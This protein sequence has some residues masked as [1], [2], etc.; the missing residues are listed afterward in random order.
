MASVV[1]IRDRS[2]PGETG[3]DLD[4]LFGPLY[5]RLGD[6]EPR[7]ELLHRLCEQLA[8]E[9][10]AAMVAIA[11]KLDSG[12][13]GIEAVAPGNALW[14]ELQAIPERWDGTV[15]GQGPAA[16]SIKSGE[17][18]WISTAEE[19]FR[20]WRAAATAERVAAAGAWPIRH[21][22]QTWL[23]EVF[24]PDEA[25]F[26]SGVVRRKMDRVVR[27][28][29]RFLGDEAD[30]HQR[31]LLASAM[32]QAGHAA[33]ITNLEGEIVWVNR[34]FT[35]L[36]GYEPDEVR[37]KTPRLLHSGQQGLRYYRDLWATIRAGRV[38]SG[39]TVDRDRGGND[40]TVRQT[41]SPFGTGD[42][43]THYLSMHEDISD[44]AV[45]R[46]QEA[47]KQ[48]PDPQT[49]LLNPARFRAAVDEAIGAAEPF[50]L[51]LMSLRGYVEATAGLGPELT[52]AIEN[53][54]AARLRTGLGP[55]WCAG[56]DKPGEYLLLLRD[57]KVSGHTLPQLV[58]AL[59]HPFPMLGRPLPVRPRIGIARFPADGRT[60]DEL[61]RHADAQLADEPMGRPVRNNPRDGNRA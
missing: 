56:V 55:G 12:A 50:T 2:N 24:V 4:H 57:L 34:A 11:R 5:R 10:P 37:G 44:Q 61:W 28:L 38:W 27:G 60:C 15:A 23:L 53:E 18:A 51:A 30:Q 7:E 42:R 16:L 47:L 41:V 14:V 3:A 35:R 25:F 32:E 22:G 52:E 59:E 54:F 39:E 45:A 40:H 49:G 19:G 9:L 20:P 26:H 17:P 8:D 36:Y 58:K 1:P 21:A 48:E 13:V 29:A 43:V 33:F 31:G 46:A 6:G